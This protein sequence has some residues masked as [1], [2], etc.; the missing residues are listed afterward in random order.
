MLDTEETKVRKPQRWNIQQ[1]NHSSGHKWH[2][3]TENWAQSEKACVLLSVRYNSSIP[4]RAATNVLLYY[5]V[6]VCYVCVCVC[7][8]VCVQHPPPAV[9]SPSLL[10]PLTSLPPFHLSQLISSR[11]PTRQYG[12]DTKQNQ[13][14]HLLL[15]M[16]F[17]TAN[18]YFI[19]ISLSLAHTQCWP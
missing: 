13:I 12:T 1:N 5:S 8:C 2:T 6:V 9:C 17:E 15:K 4:P 14:L 11:T 10:P 16:T 3:H 7:V 18:V 19:N